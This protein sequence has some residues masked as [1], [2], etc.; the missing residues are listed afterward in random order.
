MELYDIDMEHSFHTKFF[1]HKK[2]DF[3]L[4][5]LCRQATVLQDLRDSYH[6]RD[7]TEIKTFRDTQRGKTVFTCFLRR[8]KMYTHSKCREFDLVVLLN[9]PLDIRRIKNQT[10]CNGTVVLFAIRTNTWWTEIKDRSK[11]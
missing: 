10:P 7:C 2:K 5:L 4:T 6:S 1:S 11:G 3:V 8:L 9:V